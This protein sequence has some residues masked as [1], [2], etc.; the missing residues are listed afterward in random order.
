MSGD[1]TPKRKKRGIIK[2]VLLLAVFAIIT[3]LIVSLVM[4][5]ITGSSPLTNL[6]SQRSSEISVNEFNFNVGRDR[7]FANLD[8]SIAAVGTLGLK[9]LDAD[10]RETLRD[11]FRMSQPAILSSG[12]RGIA[13]D[14]G[15]SSVRV[16]NG[17]QVLS[18][19]ETEGT[20][21]SASLNK[22]GWFCV[23][24]QEG[25]VSRGTITVY[26]S[27]GS[28]VLRAIKETGFVLSAELSHDNRSLAILNYTTTGSRVSFYH[29]LD[30]DKDEPD[31][32][33][34][35]TSGLIIDIRYLEN[36][37]VLVVSTD[38]LFL[39]ERSGSGKML[40][41]YADKRLG[42]YTY[43]GD[44]IVLHLYDYGIGY[45]GRLIT[46][47]TDGTILAEKTAGR[48][49]ISMSAADNSFILLKNDGVLFLDEELEEFQA[50][51]E[52]F[53]AAGASRVLAVSRD[54]ALATSDNS[55]VVI[56][57]NTD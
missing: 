56:R 45:Q 43:D 33:F 3:F 36:G 23:V 21:V 41:P 42:G 30:T 52:D 17:T 5:I 48:E 46:L 7:M 50:S 6:F 35:Y 20:I 25:G 38:A 24:T 16:F 47:L 39:I 8:G 26:N 28:G 4:W 53:S 49:I 51:E 18:S 29:G 31:H 57:R 37:D 2:L 44:F 14:I 19:I 27:S 11:S 12:E 40:F 15:G 9:V 34:D 13:F 22:N 54:T 10:G 55:A 32:I 1:G